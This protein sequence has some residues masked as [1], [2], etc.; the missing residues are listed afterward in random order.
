MLLEFFALDCSVKNQMLVVFNFNKCTTVLYLY[1][2]LHR[3]L[4]NLSATNML[5][6][7]V[8]K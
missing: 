3:F 1:T 4:R 7:I 6:Q 8:L 5:L 2:I